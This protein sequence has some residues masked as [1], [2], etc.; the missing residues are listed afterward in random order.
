MIFEGILCGGHLLSQFL[1]FRFIFV[2]SIFSLQCGHPTGALVYV[3]QAFSAREPSGPPRNGF[4]P[5]VY[6]TGLGLFHV[7]P[8]SK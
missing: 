6:V 7:D 5:D 1:V 3:R 4:S 2:G 8:N